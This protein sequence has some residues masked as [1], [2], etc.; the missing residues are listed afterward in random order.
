MGYIIIWN[1]GSRDPFIQTDG[2]YF[3][4]EFSSFEDAREAAEVNMDNE[5]FRSYAIFEEVT[6]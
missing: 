4:E 2:H 3:K 5:H 1:P 6:S